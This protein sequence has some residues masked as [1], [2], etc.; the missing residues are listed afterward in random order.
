MAHKVTADPPPENLADL[1]ERLGGVPLERVWTRPAPGTATEQ[2]IVRLSGK[3]GAKLLELVEGVL[4]EKAVGT[5]EALLGGIIVHLLWVYL[6]KNKRGKALPG[7]ALLRLMP[8]LVRVPDVA[9]VSWSKMPGGKFPKVRLADLVPDLAIEILSEGNTRGEINR[10]LKEYFLAGTTLVWI[11]DPRKETAQVYRAPDD[12]R[13]VG[14]S[15]VLD[16]EQVLPGFQLS[17]ADLFAR[18][19]EE[20]PAG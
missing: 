4:V 1:M 16:G 12:S 14:K 19:D 7:D 8:G 6:E 3:P 2:D 17:L 9:F 18:A 5:R 20:E 13:R 11:I 10:K 15:G